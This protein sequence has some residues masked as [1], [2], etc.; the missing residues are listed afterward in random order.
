[1]TISREEND[2]KSLRRLKLE[3][4]VE[5]SM[6]HALEKFKGL[7]SRDTFE[8]IFA[9]ALDTVRDDDEAYPPQ[10]YGEEII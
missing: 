1:M 5:K 6:I 2:Q 9:E 3:I 4:E 8:Q 10:T 7:V